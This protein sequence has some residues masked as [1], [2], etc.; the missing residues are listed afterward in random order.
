[1]LKISY[2]YQLKIFFIVQN[3]M[4][5]KMHNVNKNKEKFSTFATYEIQPQLAATFVAFIRTKC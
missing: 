1:M 3:L 5:Y 2:F 4:R